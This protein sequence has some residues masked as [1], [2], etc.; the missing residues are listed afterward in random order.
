MA[1]RDGEFELVI[2]PGNDAHIIRFAQVR[3]IVDALELAIGRAVYLR[4]GDE[5]FGLYLTASPEFGSI[6]LSLFAGVTFAGALAAAADVSQVT[7]VDLGDIF[8]AMQEVV[9]PRAVAAPSKEVD[10]FVT[11]QGFRELVEIVHS[12]AVRAGYPSVKIKTSEIEIELSQLGPPSA[13]QIEI[14]RLHSEMARLQDSMDE[15]RAE[16]VR[17][18][19]HRRSSP[20]VRRAAKRALS[21]AQV[22]RSELDEALAK[23]RA[24]G[25]Q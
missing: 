4:L 6:K 12:E 13:V 21:Q 23:L 1:N 18:D 25:P 22:R 11:D 24:Q 15:L 9:A 16:D 5:K 14:E 2:E 20:E 7:G 10:E 17:T 8:E 19:H 3:L